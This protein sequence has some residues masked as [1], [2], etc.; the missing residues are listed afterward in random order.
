MPP[1]ANQEDACPSRL[2]RLPP[3]NPTPHQAMFVHLPDVAVVGLE[4][5]ALMVSFIT[6]SIVL[7]VVGLLPESCR[8]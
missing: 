7:G 4:D 2:L 8:R 3:K 5:M 6:Q 1:A